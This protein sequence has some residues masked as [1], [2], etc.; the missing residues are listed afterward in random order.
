MFVEVLGFWK[1]SSLERLLKLLPK[2][3]PQRYS[4]AI[5]DRLKVD[6]GALETLA[7][8]VLRFKEYPNAPELAALLDRIVHPQDQEGLGI[9]TAMNRLMDS[10]R[11]FWGEAFALAGAVTGQILVR[12][13]IFALWGLGVYA[14][15]VATGPNFQIGVEVAPYEVAGAVLGMLLVLRTNA[16]YDA[17]GKVA[18]SGGRS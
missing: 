5:S 14:L 9:D 8:P 16:G 1:Q 13:L 4:L 3:G 10:G 15:D 2:H 11:D 12:T 18:S 7:G 17:G 6:E